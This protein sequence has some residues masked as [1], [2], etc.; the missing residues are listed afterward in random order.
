M[1]DLTAKIRPHLFR[2]DSQANSLPSD[3]QYLQVEK[4]GLNPN[5]IEVE[6]YSGD[7]IN[8]DDI[9]LVAIYD[10]GSYYPLSSDQFTINPEIVPTSGSSFN[11]TCS[12]TDDE[13]QIFTCDINVIIDS[14]LPE[15]YSKYIINGDFSYPKLPENRTWAV[16]D[17]ETGRIDNDGSTAGYIENF[18]SE[19]FG[20]K[21]NEYVHVNSGVELQYD[22]A[23]GNQYAELIAYTVN[24]EI[25]QDIATIPGAKYKWTLRHTSLTMF[26]V[27]VMAVVIHDVNRDPNESDYQEATRVSVNG[28]GDEIGYVGNEIATDRNC[29]NHINFNN[30]EAWEDYEGSYIVPENQTLTRFSFKSISGYNSVSGNLIDNVE[31]AILVNVNYIDSLTNELVETK[32]TLAFSK[33]ELD[34]IPVHDGYQFVKFNKDMITKPGNIYLIYQKID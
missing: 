5:V 11:L 29:L 32:E 23:Y 30:G 12:Y 9:D 22:S 4:I 20:W 1:I 6:L 33:P 18:D 15:G 7:K 24:N 28:C 26:H 2:Y 8:K 19:K 17:P 27:D 31:F 16:I 13:G 21:S 34:N 14:S 3:P 25:Y 10:N